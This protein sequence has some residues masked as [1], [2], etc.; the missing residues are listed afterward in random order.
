[1]VGNVEF[2]EVTEVVIEIHEERSIITMGMI[3]FFK[4]FRSPL[5]IAVTPWALV[6]LTSPRISDLGK[7]LAIAELNSS[8]E[9]VGMTSNETISVWLGAARSGHWE[10]SSRIG[11]ESIPS[12][13]CS[14]L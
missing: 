12:F 10:V 8:K 3:S 9:S 14:H 2:L 1:M 7:L 13:G 11:M 4:Q 6:C 5:T